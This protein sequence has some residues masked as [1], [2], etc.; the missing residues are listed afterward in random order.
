MFGTRPRTQWRSFPN[1]RGCPASSRSATREWPEQIGPK[2]AVD[3]QISDDGS[4]ELAESARPRG[5]ATLQK[6]MSRPAQ[7]SF[8][9]DRSRAGRIWFQ[10]SPNSTDRLT[11]YQDRQGFSCDERAW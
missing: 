3:L 8:A 9:L 1:D 7:A 5:S 11:A 6:L 10:F 4:R 2:R